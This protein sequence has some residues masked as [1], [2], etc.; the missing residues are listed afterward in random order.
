[1][2]CHCLCAEWGAPEDSEMIQQSRSLKDTLISIL[3]SLGS[4]QERETERERERETEKERGR[5]CVC[6]FIRVGGQY[7]ICLDTK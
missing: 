3:N 4:E 7:C 2:I 1:M 6:F 5:M